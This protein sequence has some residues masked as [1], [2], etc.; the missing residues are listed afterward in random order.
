MSLNLEAFY[1]L[2]LNITIPVKIVIYVL[3]FCIIFFY[4]PN[5]MKVFAKFLCNLL[6][7]DFSTHVLWLGFHAFP[8]MPR[9]CFRLDGFL[10][11]F[12]FNELLG[13]I[14][15]STFF[16]NTVNASIAI[17]LSFQFRLLM[18]KYGQ[19]TCKNMK[20]YIYGYCIGLHLLVTSVLIGLYTTWPLNVD[21]HP[22][23]KLEENLFCYKPRAMESQVF[24]LF[25]IAFLVLVVIGITA[26]V[27][28]SFREV[29]KNRNL[30]GEKTAK[31]QKVFL[32]SLIFLSGFPINIGG[33]PC[34]IMCVVFYFPEVP[35]AQLI[36]VICFLVASIHGPIMCVSTLILFKPYRTPILRFVKKM[37]RFA[38]IGPLNCQN[39]TVVNFLV[40]MSSRYHIF[41]LFLFILTLEGAA[42]L[43][44]M[45]S[46]DEDDAWRMYV[47]PYRIRRY[48]SDHA[49]QMTGYS[50]FG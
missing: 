32:G 44:T 16:I 15:F 9:M 39:V 8:M 2:F 12:Y 50:F 42:Q 3:T 43:Y 24:I 26:F 31:M 13:H 19:L 34:I 10:A 35:N 30:I 18:I 7:W 25:F 6:F 23:S 4:T 29:N 37:S 11:S 27:A 45:R 33:I 1:N 28:L 38:Q 48:W 17:F 21:S 20:I 47:R 14:F 22:D 41:F 36:V 46:L 40:T 5:S 49:A